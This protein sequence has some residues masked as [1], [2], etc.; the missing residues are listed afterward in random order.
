[1]IELTA[2]QHQILSANGDQ[3]ARAHDPV[4][5]EEYVLVR[6]KSM[7]ASKLCSRRTKNG[8]KALMLPRWRFLHAMVGTTLGW[9][10]MMPW[11]LE[12][13][14]KRSRVRPISG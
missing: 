10:F 12:E 5:N 14:P 1:M 2:E 7:N 3:P 4:T 13:S 11:I 6:P 8:C 9:T